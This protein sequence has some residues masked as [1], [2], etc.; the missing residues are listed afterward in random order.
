MKNLFL[1]VFLFY[2]TF[3]TTAFPLKKDTT[4]KTI[5][6]QLNFSFTWF[7]LGAAFP[8]KEKKLKTLPYE[9]D[10]YLYNMKGGLS[11]TLFSPGLYFKDKYGVEIVFAFSRFQIKEKSFKNYLE[12]KYPGYILPEYG[13][14]P[15]YYFLDNIEF[16]ICYK[17][18]IKHFILEPKFQ[19]G[20]NDYNVYTRGFTLKE[21]GS[22]QFIDIN[23]EN[24]NLRKNN[25]SYHF[26]LN[27]TKRFHPS[28]LS[29][30]IEVALKMEYLIVPTRYKFTHTESTFGE[31]PIINEII[32]K[33][34]H[35]A[36][37]IQLGL[38]FFFKK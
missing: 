7:E 6:R 29:Y 8:F 23:F 21:N 5:F 25:F 17:K 28:V 14:L 35:P 19:L 9:I 34:I 26:I 2:Y 37:A 3:Q 30:R 32:I 22:N 13:L 31:P 4:C 33:Q 12:G 10:K 24:E 36:F 20:I 16:R 38:S 18:H 15:F 27:I 11:A 1:F